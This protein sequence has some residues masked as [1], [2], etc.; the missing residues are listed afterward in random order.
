ML[1]FI[2]K[3][4]PNSMSDW[5]V[6]TAVVAILVMLIKYVPAFLD[7]ALAKGIDA[8]FEKLGPDEDWLFVQFLIYL[9]RKYGKYANA[10]KAREAVDKLL[11]LL[12]VQ[13]RVFAGEKVRAKLY[14]LVTK[15]F[16]S[17]KARIEKEAQ[18]HAAPPVV[19][20]PSDGM[21]HISIQ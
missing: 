7:G 13:Y 3:L 17:A 15:I 20:K 1:D 11:T 14:E 5:A 8:M 16:E 9:E 10:D 18:E 19:P 6:I 2:L 21:N 4:V 12:P